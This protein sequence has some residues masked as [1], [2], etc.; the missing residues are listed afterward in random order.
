MITEFSGGTIFTGDDIHKFRILAFRS[1]MEL[2]LAGIYVVR[3]RSV[4]S[5]VKA[6]FGLTGSNRS[7]YEAFC[8][9]HGLEFKKKGRHD[10]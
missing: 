9:M 3:H 2:G 10:G 8:T 5:I 7:V 1:A 4:F 6:E